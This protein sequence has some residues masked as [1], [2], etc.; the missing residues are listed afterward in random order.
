MVE[1]Q[2][3][4]EGLS[5][6]AYCEMVLKTH[7]DMEP[8]ERHSRYSAD[9][10]LIS[11]INDAVDDLVNSID[12]LQNDTTPDFE[13]LQSLRTM[14]VMALWELLK[15]EY[16]PEEREDAIK[17]AALR[18]ADSQTGASA[19][20]EDDAEAADQVSSLASLLAPDS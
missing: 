6:S 7:H 10:D 20:S 15:H 11:T 2:A 18:L 9:K 5:A 1:E 4:Q 16:S 17:R 19:L 8:E 3:E 13:H 14:Y 12:E